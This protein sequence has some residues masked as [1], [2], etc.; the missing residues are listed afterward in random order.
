MSASARSSRR[1]SRRS[2]ARTATSRSTPMSCAT[3]FAA[4]AEEI[5]QATGQPRTP[6]AGGR[7]LPAHRRRQHGERDQAGLGAEGPR[8]HPLR[9]AML[10]RRRRPARLPGRRRA[11]HGDGVH[12]PLRRRALRLWHGPRRP[13]RD[14]R[15]GGRGP[16]RRR[17]RCRNCERS[18]DRLAAE[19]T[20]ALADAGRR[21]R[22][23]SPR[24]ARCICATPAPRRR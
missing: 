1:I 18:A 4:L 7:G 15:A 11:R 13:D 8:R 10:R 6:R 9:P 23:A 12:P 14:A 24:A 17:T 5:A 20:A 2:S 19:A 21:A 16:A 3:K 22:R